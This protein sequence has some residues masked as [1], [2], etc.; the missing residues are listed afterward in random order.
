MAVCPVY[1]TSFRECDAPRGRLALL[2]AMRCA[3]HGSRRLK[4]ILSRCLL[5]G[6]CA[7]VCANGVDTV[8]ILQAGRSRLFRSHGAF[9]AGDWISR[10]EGEG[11]LPDKVVS[12][13]GTLLQALT[14]KHVPESSGLYLR[15]PLRFFTDRKTVP[16]IS[17]VPFMRGLTSR[18]ATR[19]KKARVGLFVGCGTNYLFPEVAWALVSILRRLDVTVIVPTGQVCCGLPA[20]VSGN[21]GRAESLARKNIEAFEDA[22]VDAVVTVCASCGAHLQGL[23]R[24]FGENS[25][26]RVRA[27][28]L[29][30]KH[31]DAMAFLVEDVGVASL[32]RESHG[33]ERERRAR[34]VCLV[35]YHDPCHLRIT[36]GVTDAPRAFLG[37]LPGV[38]L[39]EA[40]HTGRCC[41]H[42]GGFNLSHF[43]I[44]MKILDRRM[45]DFQSV[46]PDMIVTGCTG[47]LLQFIEGVSRMAP[48]GVIGVCHP[49]VLAQK[50]LS[51]ELP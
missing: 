50:A 34:S 49:L 37:M 19:G 40:P 31:K 4:E 23:E 35:A 28:A 2:E 3:T 42:G 16:A 30:D 11:A 51:N 46:G 17:R 44:S 39:V 9:T 13:G 7:E 33:D 47:C 1:Q 12:K 5:C 38:E 32:L 10:S 43:D 27:K 8:S 26:W 36:Q 41:G 29:A 25:S 21:D 24:F 22:H 20:F 15:F 6:A 14:C 18:E 48:E 45:K